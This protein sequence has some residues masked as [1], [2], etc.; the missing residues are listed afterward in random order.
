MIAH[1]RCD[2]PLPITRRRNPQGI[3]RFQGDGDGDDNGVAQFPITHVDGRRV[4]ARSG[5]RPGEVAADRDA[6]H[7]PRIQREGERVRAAG[8]RRAAIECV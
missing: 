6:A 2:R 7:R 1:A 4:N 3:D 8:A 5:R